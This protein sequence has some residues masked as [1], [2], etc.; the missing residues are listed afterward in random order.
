MRRVSLSSP[1]CYGVDVYIGTMGEL[2][3]S[4]PLYIRTGLA[5]V[6]KPVVSEEQRLYVAL[7]RVT[8][9]SVNKRISMCSHRAAR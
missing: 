4:A 8:A 2:T 9:A 7:F 5:E 3:H 1:S 6:V